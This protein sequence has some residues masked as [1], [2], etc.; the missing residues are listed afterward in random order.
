MTDDSNRSLRIA[1][2][3]EQLS[4]ASKDWSDTEARIKATVHI[5]N[6]LTE[7]LNGFFNGPPLFAFDIQLDT[8]E[9]SHS[10]VSYDNNQ[11][12]REAFMELTVD[13]EGLQCLN[14]KIA[15][16]RKNLESLGITI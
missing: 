9:I 5:L 4:E 6:E 11:T 12:S 8:I 7:S 14:K 1:G 16:I 3:T 13:I 10:V 15:C 2:L